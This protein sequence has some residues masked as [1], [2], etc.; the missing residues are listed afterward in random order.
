MSGHTVTQLGPLVME[1]DFQEVREVKL[2]QREQ[3]ADRDLQMAMVIGSKIEGEGQVTYR[4]YDPSDITDPGHWGRHGGVG[5]IGSSERLCRSS[6][7][8]YISV[9]VNGG[10]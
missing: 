10:G 5:C 6:D 7:S 4:V 1:L 9:S 3:G 8:Y 2:Q